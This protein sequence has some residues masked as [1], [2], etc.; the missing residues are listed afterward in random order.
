MNEQQCHAD[1]CWRKAVTENGFCLFHDDDP[2]KT[3]EHFLGELRRLQEGNPRSWNF[4]GFVFPK[5]FPVEYF[6][7]SQLPEVT[8]KN[9][10]FRGKVAFSNSKFI[11]ACQ[12]FNTIFLDDAYFIETEFQKGANFSSAAFN[13]EVYFYAKF[14]GSAGFRDTTFS[15]KAVMGECFDQ[16]GSFRYVKFLGEARFDYVKFRDEAY[17][18]DANFHD[19]AIFR[20]AEF[21]KLDFTNSKFFKETI[22]QNVLFADVAD[23]TNARFEDSVEFTKSNF[24]RKGIFQ[25]MKPYSP[26]DQYFCKE[27]DFR[28]L[29]LQNESN[30]VF[31]CL[32]LSKTKFLYT[33]VTNF[34]FEDVE[35]PEKGRWIFKRKR[36]YEDDQEYWKKNG[37]EIR[38]DSSIQNSLEILYRQL[39]HSCESRADY[40]TAGDFHIGE[41][42]FKK[43]LRKPWQPERWL[44]S[45][46]MLV[47]YYGEKWLRPILFLILGLPVFALL[48]LIAGAT[49]DEQR[50][51][52]SWSFFSRTML[53]GLQVAILQRP[54]D[55]SLISNWSRLIAVSWAIL[56]PIFIALSLLAI[57]R[58]FKR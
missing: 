33:D 43:S 29:N 20:K 45:A 53:Y 8:F 55:I 13:G 28:Y 30:I 21:Q 58:R 14:R 4:S 44:L 23:F 15:S 18:E 49:V 16:G 50:M 52:L 34:S 42:E 31:R 2:Q 7:N 36:L 1:G 57:R 5:D 48:I 19:V 47:S 27:A 56:G 22:F 32:D 10:I 40:E 24:L 37:I 11:G 39:K 3:F 35:W 46:Y 12:F 26:E 38:R 51:D 41:M 54:E 17:F 6:V 25:K 9:A